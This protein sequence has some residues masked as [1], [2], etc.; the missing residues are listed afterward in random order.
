MIHLP[1]GNTD[2]FD[3]ITGILQREIYL[4]YIICPDNML[5]MLIDLAKNGFILKKARSR[6]YPAETITDYTDDLALLANT[7]AQATSLLYSLK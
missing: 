7:L 6:W 3:I 4:C 1:D 2:F 5:W